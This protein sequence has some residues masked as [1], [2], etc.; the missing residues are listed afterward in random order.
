LHGELDFDNHPLLSQPRG[1][2]VSI[3]RARSVLSAVA[4]S[5]A[6]AL[7]TTGT[8]Q[9]AIYTG[10]WDPAYGGIFPSLGWEASAVFDVPDACLALGSGNNIPISGACSGFDVLSAEVRFYDVASPGT[11]LETFNLNPDVIV[12]GID[13]AGGM[14]TGV[15][16]GFFDYFVPTLSIAGGGTY[17]F[18]LLL[19]GGTL[20]QLAYVNPP[21]ASPGCAALPVPGTHCGFSEN[22]AT[23]VF[24]PVPEPETYALMLAGLGALGFVARR[25]RR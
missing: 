15:D 13:L 17:S 24:A 4:L 8:A 9:A 22:A 10:T 7:G 20:A 23:G 14:L 25:R 1:V 16:T 3:T 2:H 5:A 21:A 11:I 18:S 6:A 12:N 19:Y